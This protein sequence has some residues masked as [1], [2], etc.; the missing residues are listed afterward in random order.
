MFRRANLS[1]NSEPV[2]NKPEPGLSRIPNLLAFIRAT[3]FS[4]TFN[5]IAREAVKYGGKIEIDVDRYYVSSEQR[6]KVTLSFPKGFDLEPLGLEIDG[7]GND[8][9]SAAAAALERLRTAISAMGGYVD[10]NGVIL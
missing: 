7:W 2:R 1:G 8:P 3:E 10:R 5:S 6:W 4:D 9:D